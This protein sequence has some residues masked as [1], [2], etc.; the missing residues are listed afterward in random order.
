M[1]KRRIMP[2]LFSIIILALLFS[3][4]S[5][6]SL[7]TATLTPYIIVITNTPTMDM[8][9]IYTEAAATIYAALTGTASA[10][11]TNT[12][13]PPTATITE[14][15]T[16]TI[17]Q[18][19]SKTNTYVVYY[20]PTPVRT[21]TPK[22]P[23]AEPTNSDW[24]CEVT[25]QLIENGQDFSPYE[26]FDARWTIKNTGDNTWQADDVDY[27]YMSGTE[28]QTNGKLFDLPST[29]APGDSITI[30]VDMK[31]PGSSGHYET[32]W[33]L[34]RHSDVFCWLPV[35]IDVK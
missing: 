29:V 27:R 15:P 32:F 33:A 20:P 11:P 9:P 19:P 4:C 16:P 35:R 24:N 8:G 17:T 21:N 30:T 28:I 18:T 10:I 25:W 5:T 14:T 7:P 31:A 13:I 26:P 12:P 22:P 2:I 6:V 1:K 34:A 3:S 23:T